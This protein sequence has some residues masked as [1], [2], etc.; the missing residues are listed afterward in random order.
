MCEP[1]FSSP[2]LNNGTCLEW[3][4]SEV[5]VRVS[6]G[7][8]NFQNFLFK[9]ELPFRTKSSRCICHLGSFDFHKVKSVDF[10]RVSSNQVSRQCQQALAKRAYL[11]WLSMNIHQR[12]LMQNS[13]AETNMAHAYVSK[14]KTFI[15]LFILRQWSKNWT[16]YVVW[17]QWRTQSYISQLDYMATYDIGAPEKQGAV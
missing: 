1:L 4:N 5:G 7:D 6:R 15:F 12:I 3:T 9:S 14:S 2:F 16:K 11:L 10:Y 13:R 17:K 8:R